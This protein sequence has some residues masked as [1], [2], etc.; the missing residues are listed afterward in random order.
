MK[1]DLTFT[2]DFVPNITKIIAYL[3]YQMLPNLKKI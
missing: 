3:L 1:N 2:F